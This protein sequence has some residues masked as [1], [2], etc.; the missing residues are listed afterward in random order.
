[1]L[2]SSK[3]N[4]IVTVTAQGELDRYDR[5]QLSRALDHAC[6]ESVN[7]S[8]DVDMARVGFIDSECARCLSEMAETLRKWGQRLRLKASPQ[9]LRTLEMLKLA[10]VESTKPLLFDLQILRLALA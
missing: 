1:M 2:V 7:G 6:R 10:G 4:G 5:P 9:V 3:K 8:V